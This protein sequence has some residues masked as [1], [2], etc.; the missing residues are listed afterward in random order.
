MSSVS[1]LFT[2]NTCDVLE[3]A[4]L[5]VRKLNVVHCRL[6]AILDKSLNLSAFS[7]VKW[8]SENNVIMSLPTFLDFF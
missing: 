8:K 2:G 1:M 6:S 3:R 7:S 5:R 4:G